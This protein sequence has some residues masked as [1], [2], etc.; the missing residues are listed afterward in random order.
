MKDFKFDVPLFVFTWTYISEGVFKISSL[1]IDEYPLL[2]LPSL[3]EE[4][5]LNEA[6][7]LQQI[8]FWLSKEKNFIDG[9]YWV[10]NSYEDWSKQFPFWSVSTIRR[11]FGKLEE[12]GLVISGNYNKIGADRTK[13][14]S[15]DYEKVSEISPPSVQIK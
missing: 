13:W 9:R 12:S 6:I 1:L 5:G 10:F 7:V 15:I 11:I 3:A 14:Y 2:V 4:I 8:H